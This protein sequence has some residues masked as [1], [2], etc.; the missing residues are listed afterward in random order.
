MPD[1]D[2]LMKRQQV[3]ADFGEF[4]IRSQDLDEVLMEA[5]RLVGEALGTGRAK[6][7]EIEEDRQQLFLRAGV[8][9][10]PDVVGRVRLPMDERSS[11]TYSIRAGEP[12]IS[13]DIAKEDRFDVP[14]FMKEA[15]VVALVNVPIFVPG[16]RPYGILQVDDTSPREFGENEIQFLRTYATILGPVIDRLYLVEERSAV[17]ER[18][19]ADLHSANESFSVSF[20]DIHQRKEAEMEFLR[21]ISLL[22]TTFDASL[23]IIQLFKAVRDDNDTIVDF[24]W[25]LTNKQWNDRWGPMTGRRLLTEN[26]AVVESGVWDRFIQV[27][28]S[29]HPSC[30]SITMPTS[31]STAG[32]HRRSP[33]RATASCSPRS[34]SPSRSARRR[35]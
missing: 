25:V 19:F 17:R 18:M 4:A 2:E 12:V 21:I 13:Q 14:A 9:W 28:E 23:Q 7:F 5:C 31:S 27:M 16:E 32:S 20:K 6:V 24:E 3:L 30:T 26:P 34:T 10:G 35:R 33:R 1:R 11:E 8:G 15:G 29:G 22:R